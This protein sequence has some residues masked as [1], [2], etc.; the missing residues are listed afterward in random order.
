MLDE[1]FNGQ[2]PATKEAALEILQQFAQNSLVI[3]IDHSNDFQ[4]LFNN[5]LEVKINN[6]ISYTC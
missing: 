6:G 1:V 4:Q 2:P 3:V 5:I